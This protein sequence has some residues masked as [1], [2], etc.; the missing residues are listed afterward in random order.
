[1]PV[2]YAKLRYEFLIHVMNVDGTALGQYL[3]YYQ[4]EVQHWLTDKQRYYFWRALQGWMSQTTEK[5]FKRRQDE[6]VLKNG[7][8]GVNDYRTDRMLI[9]IEHL[10]KYTPWRR[11]N[12]AIILSTFEKEFCYYEAVLQ[13]RRLGIGLPD[14][15]V[16]KQVNHWIVRSFVEY[17]AWKRSKYIEYDDYY[18]S[19]RRKELTERQYEK[20]I[21]RF[22]YVDV[23]IKESCGAFFSKL[24]WYTE[25]SIDMDLLIK[26]E[27]I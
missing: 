19:R 7:I 17:F 22:D 27:I 12:A 3:P 5:F 1:M 11:F 25:Q 20:Q 8:D 18:W 23:L 13:F 16:W 6:T 26:R 14:I 4:H 15:P 21:K 9:F 10:P 2:D 24:S